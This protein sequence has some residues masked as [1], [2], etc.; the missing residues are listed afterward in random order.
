MTSEN[1]DRLRDMQYR[2]ERAASTATTREEL[3]NYRALWGE[4]Q[5]VLD[6]EACSLPND[7]TP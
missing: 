7:S 2:I 3:M 6:S 5:V 1:L 4:I